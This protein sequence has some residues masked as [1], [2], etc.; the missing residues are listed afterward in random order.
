MDPKAITC[1]CVV[2]LRNI[3][4]GLWLSGAGPAWQMWSPGLKKRESSIPG[5][6]KEKRNITEM[7]E[8]KVKDPK[9]P[10]NGDYWDKIGIK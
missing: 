2:S 4:L 3:G 9:I 8:S 7:K 10:E 6:K 1:Q 5:L